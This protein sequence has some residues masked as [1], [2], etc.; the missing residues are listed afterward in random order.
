FTVRRLPNG[1]SVGTGALTDN[2]PKQ[3]DGFSVSLNGNALAAG[4]TFKVTPTRN[5]ASGISVVLTD[6]K[7]IAAAAPLTATAG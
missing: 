7:D 3:F 6:P 2:P 1:E 4:D 5:G